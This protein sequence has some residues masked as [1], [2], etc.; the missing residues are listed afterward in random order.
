MHDALVEAAARVFGATGFE[1][2][3]T[4]TIAERAGVSI[5]S[6]Y[7][8]FPNKLALLEAAHA[9]HVIGLWEV[10]DKAC[11]EGL[12]LSWPNAL[13]HFVSATVLYNLKAGR[14]FAIFQEELPV[15]FPTGIHVDV[16]KSKYESSL[17]RLLTAHR[18]NIYVDVENAVQMVPIIGKG[19]VTTFFH[20]RP[21]EFKPDLLVAEVTQVLKKYLC[22]PGPH[23]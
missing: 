9:R 4:N 17:R 3:T 5:G 18:E 15:T 13:R 7:Q 22:E 19:V 21:K 20:S 2:A 12:S 1:N 10:A 23:R 6:L 11:Q 8:Y 14:L 16:A